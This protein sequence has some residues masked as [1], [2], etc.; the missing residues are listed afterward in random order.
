MAVAF[1]QCRFENRKVT[2]AVVKQTEIIL[3]LCVKRLLLTLILQ[4]IPNAEQPRQQILAISN[5][6]LSL[7]IVRIPLELMQCFM[8]YE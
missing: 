2:S 7:L 8:K 5:S 6:V 4:L 1:L 3:N